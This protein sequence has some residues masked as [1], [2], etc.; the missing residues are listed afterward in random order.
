M[1]MLAGME[2]ST[3]AVIAS[4]I[5]LAISVAKD[6]F[7]SGNKLAARF[8]SLEKQTTA[9][10]TALRM[11]F[12]E[13]SDRYSA[14]SRVGFDAITANIHALQLGFSEFRAK[15]AEEYMRTP[16]FNKAIDEVKKDFNDRHNDLKSD[17]HRGFQETKEQLDAMAQSI[18][19]GRKASRSHHAPPP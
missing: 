1:Q 11:E 5:V 3:I 10:I 6:I 19:L 15:M 4:I 18:E 17:V 9:D 7:G 16:N 2:N 12:I 14:N 8:A 13:K